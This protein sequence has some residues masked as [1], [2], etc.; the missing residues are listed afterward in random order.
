MIYFFININIMKSFHICKKCIII[1]L[2]P[3]CWE[4]GV[5]TQQNIIEIKLCEFVS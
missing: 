4:I 1:I 5:Q 2:C 3:Q